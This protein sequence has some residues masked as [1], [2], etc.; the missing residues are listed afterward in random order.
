M[1]R[2]N[3]DWLDE[4]DDDPPT[5]RGLFGRLVED[6][7]IFAICCFLVKLGVSYLVSVKVPLIII[8]VILVIIVI[9]YRVYRR[10]D[11]DDY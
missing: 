1:L 4:R 8:A 5:D 6:V 3:R 11:H 7:I 2:R 10:R 9:I